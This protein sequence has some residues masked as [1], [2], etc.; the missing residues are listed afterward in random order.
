MRPLDGGVVFYEDFV[1]AKGTEIVSRRR[2]IT[3]TDAVVF[4]SLTGIIDPVFTDEIFAQENLFGGRVVPGPLV[5]TYAMGLTD[6]IGYGSVVA[7]LGIDEAR[8]VAPVRPEDT[9]QVFTDVV[10]TRQSESRPN[11]GI[12][13]LA[14]RVKKQD[15]TI[16]QSFKR[17]LLVRLRD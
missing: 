8:F 10:E 4:T 6:E 17:T 15:G 5:M 11:L 7:A 2:T 9:I 3:Q 14:H 12:V 1:K 13:T 16:A